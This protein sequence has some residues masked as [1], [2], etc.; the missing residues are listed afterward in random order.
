M[1]SNNYCFRLL[2]AAAMLAV[3]LSA[4]ARD[5]IRIGELNSYK[6]QPAFL[7]PYKRAWIWPSSRSMLRAG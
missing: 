5:V 7:E 6:T 3:S 1:N 4:S 2:G